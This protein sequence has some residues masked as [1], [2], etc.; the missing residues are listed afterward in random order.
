MEPLDGSIWSSIPGYDSEDDGD[1]SHSD[2][3]D[4][5]A[6][7][8]RLRG[9]L[10]ALGERWVEVPF[11]ECSAA[12]RRSKSEKEL[13]LPPSQWKW[14]PGRMPPAFR[15]EKVG[16]HV[17]RETFLANGLHATKAKDFC[18]Q[19]SAPGL[20]DSAYRGLHEFQ[21]VN[22]FPGSTELTRKDRLWTNFN[23]MAKRFGIEAFDFVPDSYVLPGQAQ[24][25][26]DVYELNTQQLWIVKPASS[27]C[28]RGI[29]L[30]RDIGKLP[31]HE[32]SVVCRYVDKPLLIQSLK[33]DLRIYVLVTSFEP[34][35]AYVYREGLA[36]FATKPYSADE[37]HLKDSYRHLTN[38]SV[39]RKSK[40]FQENQE[41]QADNVGHKWSLSALNK[42]LRYE[43]VDVDLMW[44]RI[45]DLIVKTLLCV[46]PHVASKARATA[47]YS[48]N[49]F[50]IFG[51]DVIVDEDLKPWLLEVNLSPSMATDSPLDW[52]IKSSLLSDSFNLAGIAHADYR[53][54]ITSR[55]RAK[56]Q[57]LRRASEASEELPAAPQ[58]APTRTRCASELPAVPLG[59]LGERH[60]K[61]LAHA[62]LERRR[63][64]NFI[65][66]HPTTASVKRYAGIAEALTQ[67]TL[68]ALPLT[69]AQVLW[70]V[71]LGPQPTQDADFEL[72][73]SEGE[74]SELESALESVLESALES[75]LES[76]EQ[77]GEELSPKV[78][79]ECGRPAR[80]A[81]DPAH[82]ASAVVALKRVGMR[83]GSRLVL[84]EYLLRMCSR[85]SKLSS[86]Q[87][88][89]LQEAEG[90]ALLLKSF[91]QQV[92]LLLRTAGAGSEMAC[93]SSNTGSPEPDAFEELLTTCQLCLSCLVRDSW[94]T[95][96]PR[97][98]PPL[99]G[100]ELVLADHLPPTFLLSPSGERAV[101]LLAGLGAL[102]LEWILRSPEC[103][104]EFRLLAQAPSDSRC[105][106]LNTPSLMSA[107]LRRQ[108][109]EVWGLPCG[110]LSEILRLTE[111]R[112][113]SP[114]QAPRT[115]ARSASPAPSPFGLGTGGTAL[116]P[117]PR[118]G[119]DRGGPQAPRPLSQSRR[120][121]STP[122]LPQLPHSRKQT[123]CALERKLLPWDRGLMCAATQASEK[124]CGA[125]LPPISGLRWKPLPLDH[126]EIE[127]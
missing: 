73:E 26:L 66:L 93:P 36:R 112:H 30:L 126:R 34:L 16:A 12:P 14:G 67:D 40:A 60:L 75:V 42:H 13:P 52:Q 11:L 92:A 54:V 17:V 114:K 102:D 57:E 96:A 33:F 38:Y 85:C 18:M 50:E 20:R 44:S 118:G 99:R 124:G 22:H 121:R 105:P 65:C 53:A 111:S 7:D 90:M 83:Y 109:G 76:E 25:F 5:S 108:I 127:L 78:F 117:A 72:P 123:P 80:H 70:S 19:W 24:E 103:A 56:L 77:K 81:Y 35:R 89:R 91:R 27:C 84:M 51:F 119:G 100:G 4:A 10:S 113:A 48:S 106:P 29:F 82:A 94:A 49:C 95:R 15:I 28:G 101:A 61:I 41:A 71:L 23:R 47:P 32:P 63:C 1:D 116:P 43:G 122:V 21:K 104:P 37:E 74:E 46:E 8:A 125:S 79:R 45:M 97:G 88:A 64:R 69:L 115:P 39:N 86:A 55:M 3:E 62:L 6:D 58:R 2:R 98:T 68:G 87:E 107:H 120:A 31:L 9:V 59:A 110:P